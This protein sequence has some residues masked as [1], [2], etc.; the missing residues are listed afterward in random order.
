MRAVNI[1]NVPFRDTSSTSLCLSI[2][3]FIVRSDIIVSVIIFD[4]DVGCGYD[5]RIVRSSAERSVRT[6]D[7]RMGAVRINT[8]IAV[9]STITLDIIFVSSTFSP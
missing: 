4:V 5:G 8:M 3:P 9:S 1:R 6:I 2:T 7:S